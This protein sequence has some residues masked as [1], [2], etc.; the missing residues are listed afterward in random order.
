MNLNYLRIGTIENT[1]RKIVAKYNNS[2]STETHFNWKNEEYKVQ[3][4]IIHWE[5]SDIVQVFH[6]Y[7]T[8]FIVAINFEWKE[9]KRDTLIVLFQREEQPRVLTGF[10]NEPVQCGE[11]VSIGKS[12]TDKSVLIKENRINA[13]GK[14]ETL[15]LQIRVSDMYMRYTSGW[16]QP[17]NATMLSALVFNYY[18]LNNPYQEILQFVAERNEDY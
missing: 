16:F 18:A 7:K 11:Y 13:L 10:T 1:V 12:K 3:N 15:T 8:G 4:P 17:L 2:Y 6:N 5:I 9:Y 14:F